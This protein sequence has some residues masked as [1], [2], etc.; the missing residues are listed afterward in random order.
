MWQAGCH[1]THPARSEAHE[2]LAIHMPVCPK[3]ET[4][5]MSSL[6]FYFSLKEKAI[7]PPALL[8]PTHLYADIHKNRERE[9]QRN[10]E[11]QFYT[12]SFPKSQE[13]EQEG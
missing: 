12:N 3:V 5:K 4:W 6:Y 9:R 8:K 2:L 10:T 7:H 11:V 1:L 13:L